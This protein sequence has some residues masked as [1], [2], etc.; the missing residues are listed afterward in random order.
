MPPEDRKYTKTH[1][2]VKLE[3][4]IITLGITDFAQEQLTDIVFVELPPHGKALQAGDAA[5]VLE[6]VKSVADVYSPLAGEITAVNAALEQT[7]ETINQDAFGK[8]WLVKLKV[9]DTSPLANMLSA[10]E[11]QDYLDKEAH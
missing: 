8:G 10:Q 11:Y 7:P 6:S 9:S 3:G 1:E 5:V 2:W 4:N